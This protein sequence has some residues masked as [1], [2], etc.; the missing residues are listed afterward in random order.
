MRYMLS[1]V[2][3]LDDKFGIEIWLS[4]TIFLNLKNEIFFHLRLYIYLFVD[5][6]GDSKS[7]ELGKLSQRS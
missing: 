5:G 4:V 6:F 7:P 3:S 2:L 1:V